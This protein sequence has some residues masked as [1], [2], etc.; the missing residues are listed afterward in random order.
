[1]FSSHAPPLLNF[2]LSTILLPHISFS[3]GFLINTNLILR[4]CWKFGFVYLFEL[5]L[6]AI[7]LI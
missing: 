3:L 4:L 5:F 6:M 2:L 7:F 1:M